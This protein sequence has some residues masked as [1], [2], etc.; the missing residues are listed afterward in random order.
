MTEEAQLRENAKNGF[1]AGRSSSIKE[2]APECF[3]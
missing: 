3:L 1:F 2:I